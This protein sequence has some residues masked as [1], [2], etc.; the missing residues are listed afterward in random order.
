MAVFPRMRVN[1]YERIYDENGELIAKLSDGTTNPLYDAFLPNRNFTK[2]QEFTEQLSVDWFIREGL[3]LK[4]QISIVKG[5]TSGENYKSPFSAEFLNTVYNSENRMQ[6]Y[7]PI[8]KRGYLSMTDGS[9]LGYNGNITLNYNTLFGEKHIL[10][11]GIGCEVKQ[12]DSNSHGFTLTGFPDDRYSDPAFAIQFKE[13]SRATS[14][15][16]KSR[17]IGFFA[18]GNYIYDDRYFADVSVR[19]DGSPNLE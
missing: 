9:S 8:A 15:E 14:D 2:M 10:Y 11:A 7:L 18:N 16:S 6:E 19:I 1:P 4:G 3:R 17:S 13:N 12:D 5:E